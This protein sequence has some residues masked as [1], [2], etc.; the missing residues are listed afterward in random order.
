MSDD[1]LR[2]NRFTLRFADAAV[3]AAYAEEHARKAVRPV[4]IALICVSALTVAYYVLAVHVFHRVLVVTG[5]TL[6]LRTVSALAVCAVVYAL[7]HLRVFVKRQ[8]LIMFFVVCVMSLGFARGSGRFPLEVLEARGFLLMLFHTFGI[9]S[10][11]RLR[12]PQAVLAGWI[13]GAFYAGY[14]LGADLL[15]SGGAARHAIFLGL[16]NLFGHAH[17]LPDG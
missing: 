10:I 11:Y 2:M 14:L 7:A 5:T 17:L 12:F 15:S 6:L 4:R 13:G 16:A 8:Q 3:E 1:A 9:F